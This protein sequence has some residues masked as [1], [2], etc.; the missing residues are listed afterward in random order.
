MSVIGS[1]IL[2]GAA[3]QGGYTI[4]ESLRFNSSQS[5]YLS[6]TLASS[7]TTA[8]YSAWVKRGTLGTASTVFGTTDASTYDFQITFT[9][10][11]TIVFYAYRSSAQVFDLVT[12][13]VFRDPSAWYHIVA[14]LNTPDATAANRVQLF[15]N[16]A[17]VTSFSTAAYPAQ[18]ATTPLADSRVFGIG[19]RGNANN[20]Y[21]DGYLTEVN[22]IDGQA[23]TPSSFGDYNATTGVWQ[24]VGYT[25]TYG[26]NGFYLPM[27]LDNTTEGFNTVT[28]VGNGVANT[29]ISGVGFS[30]DLVWIKDRSEIDHHIL[31][32]SIRGVTKSLFSNLTNAEVVSAQDLTSFNAD[33]FT[34]GTNDRVNGSSDTFV[35]WCWDAGDTTVSNTDGSITSSVRANPAYGFSVVT[36]TG[37]GANATVGHGLGAAPKMVIV[38]KR[39][40]GTAYNW[41]VL[42]TSFI[43]ADYTVILNGTNSASSGNGALWNTTFPSS[44]VFSLGVS[45]GSNENTATYVAYC[46]SEVAGY[47]KFGSYTGTGASGNAVTTG[48]KPAF[49]MIKNT[50]ASGNWM[51][52]DATRSASGGIT[53]ELYANT[54]DADAAVLRGTFDSNGFTIDSTSASLNTSGNTYIYMA[55]K[56]TR[57]YAFWLDDS[58][59]NNDWQ[60]NGGITTDS[61]V[62]DTPTPY[63]DGGNYAVLNPLRPQLAA[64]VTYTNGNLTVY[65]PTN[66]SYYP[67]AFNTMG[68]SSGKFYWEVNIVSE[69]QMIGIGDSS[70]TLRTNWFAYNYGSSNSV[71]YA[72]NGNLYYPST[73]VS[74]WGATYTAGDVIGVALDMDAGTITFYKNNVSQGVARTGLSGEI[75]AGINNATA[76]SP[77]ST[78]NFGQRPF[79]YTPPAGFKSLHTGNLPD[80]AIVDG[81]DYFDVVT[82]TGTG[83]EATVTGLQFQPDLLWTKT[84]SNAVNHSLTS[85]G[86]TYNYSFLQT[87]TTVAEVTDAPNY[88]MIP[89][90]DGYTV[91]TGDNI[92]QVSRTFVD[93]VWKAGG[94]A[95]SNTDGSITSQVSASPTA[96]FSVVTYTGTGAN[97]TVGHGLG[98]APKIVIHKQR[99]DAGTNWATYAEPIGNTKFLNLNTTAAE[100]TSS[101]MFNNTSPTSTVMSIGTS[102]HTNL[103]TK[104]YVAYCFADVEGYSKFG[105]YTGNGSADGPFVY[106][107]GRPAFVMIKRTDAANNWVMFDS[108]RDTYNAIVNTLSADTSNSESA[109]GAGY[110]IDFLSNGF[111]PRNTTG[112]E[113]ASGG[114]YI[115]M[116]FA[117]NPFKNSLAR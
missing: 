82:R 40:G 85:T 46:F 53:N 89:T 97:A 90:A 18:N 79:A 42:H 92:N 113:N 34:V 101:S 1:N 110:N 108:S 100:T 104:D 62:T 59:N 69:G 77:T 6:R 65:L 74:G 20:N 26:T 45:S 39:S 38:K 27:K 37:T 15:V 56:D 4:E 116:A 8:T 80:S 7:G 48:F 107:G 111:K 76:S 99:T 96:G 16:G 52:Y 84:R 22:F 103:N 117:E 63:A 28:W 3:G 75:F 32:D 66:V 72:S 95:V 102:S 86:L 36:Y 68:V 93:W 54:S 51:M 58:G 49:V 61:T 29:K 44:T 67:H 87:N 88:Y 47:S 12:T 70:D 55:F 30:P 10:A 17:Q 57:E 35:A 50:S 14:V 81:S 64:G 115:Y 43:S 83:A 2:A 73:V 5:S 41:Y 33:G 94:A 71:V 60:P 91:G 106:L 9:A 24:P 98:A 114:T 11:N 23:L 21:F 25:G 105:S 109:F 31:T 78:F 112:A 19:N 13:Q